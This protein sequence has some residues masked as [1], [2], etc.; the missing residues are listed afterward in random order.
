MPEL[1]IL[2]NL[3]LRMEALQQEGTAVICQW[4]PDK[5]QH[6]TS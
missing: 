2:C 1:N 3:N 6:V 5:R 4:H